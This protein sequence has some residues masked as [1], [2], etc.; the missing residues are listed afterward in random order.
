MEP[1][2][3]VPI[4]KDFGENIDYLLKELRVGRTYD[5]THLKLEYAKRKFALFYIQGFVKDEIMTE[6]MSVI[7]HVKREDLT[8]EGIELLVRTKI[9][10]ISIATSEDLEE[11]I[12]QLLAGQCVFIIE[13]FKKAIVLDVRTYPS[14]SPEE[15]DIERVVRGSRDGFVET[16]G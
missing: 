13:G 16:I 9:P 14:R 10:H 5:V 11:V 4:S 12:S 7:Q 3:E 15:P 8:E 1:K 6:I 2:T